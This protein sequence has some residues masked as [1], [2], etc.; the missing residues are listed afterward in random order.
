MKLNFSQVGAEKPPLIIMH[1][2]FGSARNWHGV[3]KQLSDRYTVYALDLRN[4]GSSAHADVMDYSSMAQD[5]VE[6][7]D[8]H[9]IS[10]A[11]IL[12]A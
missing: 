6:F 8:A 4:H 1:G 7:L 12:G 3:A 5:V 2:L 10:D 11:I 9:N